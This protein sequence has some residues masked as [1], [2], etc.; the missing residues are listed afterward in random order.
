MIVRI[1]DNALARALGADRLAEAFAR[2]GHD[3]QRTS[4][5]GMHWLEPLVEAVEVRL[6]GH[7][8]VS[9]DLS[10]LDSTSLCCLAARAG[11]PLVAYTADLRDPRAYP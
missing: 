2:E 5:W 9:S 6:P 10:G 3:V 1:S 7:D 11:A 8:V 4:S